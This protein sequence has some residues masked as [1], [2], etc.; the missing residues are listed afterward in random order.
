M[1]DRK[2]EEICRKD[3]RRTSLPEE[4]IS[5]TKPLG[6]KKDTRRWCKGKR[7][8]E[9]VLK[10]VSYNEVKHNNPSP[11]SWTKFT[12]FWKIL[13]CTVCGK[14]LDHYYPFS[15]KNPPDWVE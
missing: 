15:K 7:G 2:K 8:R 14:E 9:H 3:N 12:M 10:C 1:K 11:A 4:D 6:G 5:P 13:I